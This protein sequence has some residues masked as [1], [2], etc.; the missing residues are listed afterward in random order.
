MS[1]IDV[2]QT[3]YREEDAEMVIENRHIQVYGTR[4]GGSANYSSDTTIEE[5]E[6]YG[7]I[8]RNSRSKKIKST[9]GGKTITSQY[10]LIT[11]DDLSTFMYIE[12]EGKKFEIVGKEI[13]R[14][15]YNRYM[16]DRA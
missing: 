8:Y 16:L 14:G 10:Y 4:V 11:K 5:L 13:I 6:I 15:R 1:R 3:K 12:A 7:T 9:V 2:D